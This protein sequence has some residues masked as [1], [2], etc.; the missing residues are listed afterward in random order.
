MAP[1]FGTSLLGF[2]LVAIVVPVTTYLTDVFGIYRASAVA[3]FVVYRQIVATVL[4]LAGPPLFKHLGL[5]WG[6]SVLGFVALATIPLPFLLLRYGERMR[7]HSKI[8]ERL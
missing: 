4:P 2:G 3:A 8:M 1:I 6:N 7:L 5:G